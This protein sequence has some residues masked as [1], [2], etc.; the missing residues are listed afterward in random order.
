MINMNIKQEEILELQIESERMREQIISDEETRDIDIESKK[1]E[2]QSTRDHYETILE[3][4][5][6]NLKT[7]EASLKEKLRA[8]T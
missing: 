7:N 6:E 2:I 1:Q 5:R 8:L 3:P 4:L